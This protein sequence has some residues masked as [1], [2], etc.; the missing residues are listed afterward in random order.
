MND[1]NI[2]DILLKDVKPSFKTVS[3]PVDTVGWNNLQWDS[4]DAEKQFDN[5]ITAVFFN[6]PNARFD[7]PKNGKCAELR[8]KPLTGGCEYLY[9][10]PQSFD[11]LLR[12]DTI[13]SILSRIH[14]C[15]SIQLHQDMNGMDIVK[16]HNDGYNLSDEHLFDLFAKHQAEIFAS[17][18]DVAKS[19][20]RGE[21]VYDSFVARP[22]IRSP[23]TA[24]GFSSD[25]LEFLL[26]MQAVSSLT[27]LNLLS[28]EKNRRGFSV[29]KT[30]A[31]GKKWLKQYEKNKNNSD[32][33]AR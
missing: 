18:L 14:S 26:T 25:R 20:L 29:Y 19:G 11:G 13:P 2:T 10:H 30:T 15:L 23:Q 22:I 4:V 32:D 33:L 21:D 12:E 27:T 6:F 16:F 24:H 28:I 1:L 5:E 3:I 31:D 17:L 7:P 9:F 8:F